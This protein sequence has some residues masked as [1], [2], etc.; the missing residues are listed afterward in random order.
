MQSICSPTA[1]TRSKRAILVSLQHRK[2]NF[3]PVHFRGNIERKEETNLAHI[4]HGKVNIPSLLR[5]AD[6]GT[7]EAD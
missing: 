3:E 7:E 2:Q 1:R 5:K 6:E 4:H